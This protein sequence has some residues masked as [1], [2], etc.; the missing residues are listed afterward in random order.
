MRSP[1]SAGFAQSLAAQ[2]DWVNDCTAHARHTKEKGRKEFR[3][4]TKSVLIERKSYAP[5]RGNQIPTI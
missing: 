5:V 4:I 3:P 2:G 1:R